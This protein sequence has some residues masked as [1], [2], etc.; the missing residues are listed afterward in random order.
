[1]ILPPFFATCSYRELEIRS[2][3]LDLDTISRYDNG[4][5][6]AAFSPSRTLT[7]RH[8]RHTALSWSF[9]SSVSNSDLSRRR[10]RERELQ[11]WTHYDENASSPRW[12]DH[13]S[14][15][16]DRS[17][18]RDTV[19]IISH[20]IAQ[21]SQM[22]T[23]GC[24]RYSFSVLLKDSPCSFWVS[25]TSTWRLVFPTSVQF[26]LSSTLEAQGGSTVGA[27]ISPSSLQAIR[28]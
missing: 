18:S 26:R 8:S 10:D 17:S 28:S 6:N 19:A 3:L 23:R 15:F 11:L 13:R 24:R 9:V 14:R 4:P 21:R 22:N 16:C 1:M 2:P 27:G 5:S 7:S 12:P 20:F 25:S